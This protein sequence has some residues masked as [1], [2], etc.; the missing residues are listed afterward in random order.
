M[1][2]RARPAGSRSRT[3]DDRDRRNML[4]NIGFGIIVLIAVLLLA[5]AAGAAWYSDNLAEAGAVNGEVITKDEHRKR[6]EID[7]FRND[8]EE[9]R[10]RTLLTAG[11]ITL[12]DYEARQAIVTQRKQS[13]E[14]LALER[15]IDAKIQGELAEQEGVTV[16]E[17]DIDA[18]FAQEATIPELRHIWLIEVAPETPEGETAPGDAEIDAAREKAEDA[19]DDL[20]AGRDWETVAREVSTDDSRDKGGD[21]GF[22]DD[23]TRL[24]PAMTDALFAVELDTPTEVVEGADG[25]FRIGRVTEIIEPRVDDALEAEIEAEDINMGDFRTALRADVTRE[26]LDEAVTAEFLVAGPQRRVAQIKLEQGVEEGEEGAVRTRHILYAPKDDPAGAGTL[27]ADDPAWEEAEEEAQA[28]YEKLSADISLFDATARAESDEAAAATTGG[29]LPYF[30]PGTGIDEDFAEAIFAEGLRDG[31]L[32]EPVRTQF[33]W[34]VIQ[35][36][37]GPTDLDWM[38]KLRVRIVE[39]GEDFAELARDNSET[40]DA[41]DGGDIGWIAKGIL[42]PVVEQQIFAT[43]VGGVSQ[44]LVVPDDGV[45]L[46]QVSEEEVRELDADQRA[47]LEQN[48]FPTWYA[49]KKAGYEIRRDPSI[50]GGF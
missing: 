10:L 48:V 35:M 17:A 26:K 42:R 31:Q 4:L 25:I 33:G 20:E 14:A 41:A 11:Q 45:Y 28:T 6:V 7:T 34:H 24:D 30:A 40:E 5:V 50:S 22:V 19:L 16:T 38:R 44:P 37:H 9:R 23:Q 1:T 47:E 29:K 32:L 49:E 15:L 13:V 18:R 3:W 27:D 21:I 46:F 12:A 39:E 2:F 43:E 36:Q 8:Y